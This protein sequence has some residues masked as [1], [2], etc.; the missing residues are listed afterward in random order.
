MQRMPT[1]IQGFFRYSSSSFTK[2]WFSLVK[3]T[4]PIRPGQADSQQTVVPAIDDLQESRTS[5]SGKGKEKALVA[6]SLAFFLLIIFKDGW[7]SDD[8]YITFRTVDN[9]VHGFVLT[10]NTDDRVQ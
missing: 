2:I 1:S 4:S 3:Q 6:F 10:W 8:S 5:Q 7:L 9:F